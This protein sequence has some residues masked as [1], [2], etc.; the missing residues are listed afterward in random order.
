MKHARDYKNCNTLAVK[1]F[2]KTI[3][4]VITLE[5][6]PKAKNKSRLDIVQATPLID[7]NPPSND[8]FN[9]FVLDTT[10]VLI[11]YI[12]IVGSPHNA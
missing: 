12:V 8:V 5:P 9:D 10:R 3:D 7:L 1:A 4:Q 6:K 11:S 2:F